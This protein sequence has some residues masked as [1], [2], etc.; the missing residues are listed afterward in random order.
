QTKAMKKVAGKLRLELAQFRELQ[1]FVQFSA[2]VDPATR[3]KIARG[4]MMTEVLKQSE[5]RPLP[6]EQQVLVLYAALNGYFGQAALEQIGSIQEKLLEYVAD[7][8]RDVLEGLRD[9]KEITPEIE[10]RMKSAI[11]AFMKEYEQLAKH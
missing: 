4:R 2:D 8:Y 11:E 3:Q 7:F 5:L 9:K 10:S 1:A 6:F